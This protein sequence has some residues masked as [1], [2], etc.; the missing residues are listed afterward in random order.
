MKSMIKS[1]YCPNFSQFSRPSCPF[2]QQRPSNRLG[3]LKVVPANLFAFTKRTKKVFNGKIHFLRSVKYVK[4]DICIKTILEMLR[5]ST[6]STKSNCELSDESLLQKGK[7][8][9]SRN[10]T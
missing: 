8:S 1:R 4:S 7:W 9:Y 3:P 10:F 6:Y 2:L 5:F